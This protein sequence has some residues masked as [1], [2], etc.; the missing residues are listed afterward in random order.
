M[1]ILFIA[2]NQHPLFP[3]IIA[4]NRDEYFSRP[5]K[6][7]HYWADKPDILAGRDLLKGGSWLGVNR[8]GG[9]CAVTNFRTAQPM[10]PKAV[11]R[12]AL[13]DHY[14]SASKASSRNH[15]EN[16]ISHLN[17]DYAQ[18]NPFNLVFG[19]AQALWAFSSQTGSHIP[20][21]NGFHSISNGELDQPWPKMS[22]GVNQLTSLISDKASGVSFKTLNQIMTNQTQAHDD[23]LPNTGIELEKEKMLSSIFIRGEQYGTRTTSVLLYSLNQIDIQETNY[24]T[25]GK[26]TDQQNFKLSKI[27]Q[28]RNSPSAIT[29]QQQT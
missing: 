21:K 19:N 24:D 12:G 14:L 25:S 8:A 23:Q 4:A 16:F 13:I 5:S 10:N 18:Y 2:L 7:M 15:H 29:T 17:R 27:D 1:C 20:L 3:L 26:V 11:S 28:K 9:F 6:N 22:Q